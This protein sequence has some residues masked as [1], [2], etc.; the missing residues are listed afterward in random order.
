[1]VCLSVLSIP[2]QWGGVGSTSNVKP[3]IW[4]VRLSMCLMKQY[5]VICQG[6]LEVVRHTFLVS[7]LHCGEWWPSFPGCIMSGEESTYTLNRKF[8]KPGRQPG[9][10]VKCKNPLLPLR[11]EPNSQQPIPASYFV[12]YLRKRTQQWKRM[13]VKMWDINYSF[14]FVKNNGQAPAL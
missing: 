13:T 3:W 9:H 11:I 14:Q 2:Q 5:S 6:G 4:T 7:A 8:G 1:M 12:H 10:L